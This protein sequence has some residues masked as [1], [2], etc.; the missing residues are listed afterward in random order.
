MIDIEHEALIYA[1]GE[2]MLSMYT[3]MCLSLSLCIYFCVSAVP[4][5]RSR[6]ARAP[7]LSNLCR[8]VVL[9]SL[10]FVELSAT[11]PAEAWVNKAEKGDE[12][13]PILCVLIEGARFPFVEQKYI[14][15]SR[16][17]SWMGYWRRAR[18]TGF[19]HDEGIG[20][21]TQDEVRAMLRDLSL[22][23]LTPPWIDRAQW[24]SSAQLKERVKS[25][26]EGPEKE[27]TPRHAGCPFERFEVS[28]K[29]RGG[30]ES[31][32][33]LRLPS[34]SSAEH[35]WLKALI[36]TL[37][38][39]KLDAKEDVW[40]EWSFGDTSMNLNPLPARVIRRVTSSVHQVAGDQIPLDRLLLRH[41]MGALSLILGR[42]AEVR[43]NGV[44]IGIWP[45]DDIIPLPPGHYTLKLTPIDPPTAPFIYKEIEI[46]KEKK[47]R[48]RLSL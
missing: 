32:L 48:L 43:I 24:R 26:E 23:L 3:F 44:F 17:H 47:T 15:Q 5:L 7:D 40:V 11:R 21:L 18:P 34:T 2:L 8:Y 20:L 39:K 35:L 45:R 1:R 31:R 19:P 36:P 16:Y 14:I 30:R 9:L 42:A 25:P 46:L 12:T 22:D 29:N 27:F 28:P 10:S 37:Y 13:T 38:Q 6:S 41:E 33:L 4:S